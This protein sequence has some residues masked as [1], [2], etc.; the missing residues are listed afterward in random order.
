MH[1]GT[2][3]MR[4]KKLR[5]PKKRGSLSQHRALGSFLIVLCFILVQLSPIIRIG[6]A[7]EK[8]G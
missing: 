3:N 1:D 7:N 6:H 5:K 4:Y 2:F 8:L